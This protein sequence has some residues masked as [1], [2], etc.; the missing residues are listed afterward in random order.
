L[1]IV[2][3]VTQRQFYLWVY[4]QDLRTPAHSDPSIKQAP[5]R[6]AHNR[7]KPRMIIS[8]SSPSSFTPVS[9]RL[10]A[11]ASEDEVVYMDDNDEFE[12]ENAKITSPGESITSARAFMR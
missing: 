3:N 1:F 8:F 12:A 9:H 5:T 10:G 11:G 2:K 6:H 7:E 4:P